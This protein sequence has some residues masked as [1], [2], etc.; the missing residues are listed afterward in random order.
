MYH[1]MVLIIVISSYTLHFYYLFIL[2]LKVCT[3]W[4]PSSNS[5]TPII[6]HRQLQIW[7][8]FLWVW[9]FL[10]KIPR[11]SEIIQHLSFFV[12]LISPSM[13]PSRSIHVASNVRISSF[14]LFKKY[15]DHLCIFFGKMSIQ[16]FC[17]FL[18]GLFLCCI[19]IVFDG[20]DSVVFTFASPEPI[21]MHAQLMVFEQANDCCLPLW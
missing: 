2:Q 21:T 9:I 4:L 11:I 16:V 15:V 18:I 7:S 14:F 20:K 6:H 5:T 19:L 13:M 10:F 12:Q 1:T 8:L 17:S 3:F